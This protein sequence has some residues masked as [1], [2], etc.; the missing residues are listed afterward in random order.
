MIDDRD[1]DLVER[2]DA[3]EESLVVSSDRPHRRRRIIFIL[4]I[5]AGIVGFLVYSELH[6][7]TTP[8]NAITVPLTPK[9]V[10]SQDNA[11][12][13]LGRLAIKGRAAKT[14]YTRKQ[15][16]NGWKDTGGGCNM[17]DRILA[18]DF[19]QETF[20]SETDCDVMTGT[21]NDP[22]T[23]K[24]IEF[25]RAKSSAVQIDHI[26]ALS[27]A[28][29]TGA[30]Q[31]TAQKRAELANDPLEL[32]AADGPANNQKGDGDAATWLPSNKPYRCQYVARQVAVKLKYNLWVTQAEHDAM[33]NVLNTCPQQV[34]PVET[35]AEAVPAKP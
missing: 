19:S 26:V 24:V 6:Q 10:E 13:A 21:L 1:N 4:L 35:P 5:V 30:Q 12:S 25:S 32:I 15:F 9:L 3:S 22:Y 33:A 11:V 28:W 14:G 7:K 2:D 23:G 16:G 20:R 17:R 18:R 8:D 31:L 27:N 29:Q 34:L